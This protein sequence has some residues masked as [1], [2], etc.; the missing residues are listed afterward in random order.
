MIQDVR[1]WLVQ[2]F[3]YDAWAN[4]QWQSHLFTPRMHEVFDHILKA[5]AIWISRVAAAAE[6]ETFDALSAAWSTAVGSDDVRRLITIDALASAWTAAVGSD[7]LGRL[8]TYRTA[9]GSEHTR[10]VGE[11]A[12]HVIDHGTYHRGQLRQLAEDAGHDWPETGLH[13]FYV[14]TLDP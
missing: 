10:S 4:R 3:A 2:G 1:T 7:D 12:R 11:I 5:Q 14:S 13:G 8:I 6:D 9:L